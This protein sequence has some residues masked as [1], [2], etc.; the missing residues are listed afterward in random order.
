M[1]AK[2]PNRVLFVGNSFTYYN[3]GLETHVKQLVLA[4]NPR[5]DFQFDRAT[6]GGATLK[7]LDG[8]SWV[9]EKIRTGRYDVVIL[10]EDLP[11]LKEHSIQPFF[12]FARKF[13]D[14][15]QAASGRTVFFMAW[16][17]ERLSWI[18][19]DEIADAHRKIGK[20]L[21]AAAAPVGLAFQRSL[22]AQ[23]ELAMLGRDKEHET[24][25]GTYLAA[26]VIY[27][28]LF[29]SSPVGLNYQPS[30]ISHQEASFLQQIAWRTVCNW[31]KTLVNSGQG[32]TSSF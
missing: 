23:P 12:D 9:H 10:Q 8:L 1:N 21:G 11:E 17:Y 30:G 27:A 3:G 5:S 22:A 15:I 32:S 20:E 24:M 6:K 26:C 14:E 19:Q 18:S 13:N 7:I 25:H 29:D 4:A 2:S 28:T 31:K 16:P